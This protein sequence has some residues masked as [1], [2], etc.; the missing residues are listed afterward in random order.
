MLELRIN[1]KLRSLD[2]CNF[3]LD[4]VQFYNWLA[5]VV[6]IKRSIGFLIFSSELV[7]TWPEWLRRKRSWG[8]S[9]FSPST[10]RTW[11]LWFL[12]PVTILEDRWSVPASEV[13]VFRALPDRPVDR[14]LCRP[15]GFECWGNDA[16]VL[17][18]TETK[19]TSG[20]RDFNKHVSWIQNGFQLNNI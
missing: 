19:H 16:S 20:Y 8:P 12:L 7:G 1:R 3:D 14:S 9:G 15:R 11:P 5:I 17:D 18:T 4:F 2:Y 10:R 6:A 13:E